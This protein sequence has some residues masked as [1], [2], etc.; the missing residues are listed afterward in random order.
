MHL[1]DPGL[2]YIL[3]GFLGLYG[4]IITGMF[5]KERFFKAKV[6]SGDDAIYTDLKTRSDGGYD[7]LMRDTER[8]RNR[9]TDNDDAT[10]TGLNRR[11]EGE[12]KELPVKRE[13]Q[14]KTEKVYQDLS[15]VT[16]DTYD[17]LQ[18]QPLPAR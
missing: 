12:Y 8:G 1:Y 5:I 10:Y 7:G 11:T 4:L 18:M 13:R 3:D 14:R 9:W 15:S 16:R 6:K 17:S 2:C